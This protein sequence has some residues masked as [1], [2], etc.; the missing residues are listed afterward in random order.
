MTSWMEDEG[1]E[2]GHHRAAGGRSVMFAKRGDHLE[3]LLMEERVAV[4]TVGRGAC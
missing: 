1:V 2:V 4:E 3:T